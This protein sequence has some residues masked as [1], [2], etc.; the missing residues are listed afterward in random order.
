MRATVVDSSDTNKLSFSLS[1][2]L[3]TPVS[4]SLAG[5]IFLLFLSLSTSIYLPNV[6]AFLSL[7]PAEWKT[8]DALFTTSKHTLHREAT[9]P[10]PPVILPPY[11]VARY[12]D[13][14]INPG[15]QST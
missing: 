15:C 5:L 13:A 12:F 8:L 10:N 1:L 2:N 7:S 9:C 14:V 11:F 4:S 3:S 6:S